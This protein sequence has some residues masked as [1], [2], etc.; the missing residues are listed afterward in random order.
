MSLSPD[1]AARR[2]TVSLFAVSFGTNVPTPIL[3]VYQQRLH[4]GATTLTAVFG[5]YAVGLVPAILLS[6][7]ASDRLGRRRVT[8]PFVALALVST[9][10]F[11]GA[12]SQEWLLFLARFLQGVV[13]GA[14]FS[15]ATAWL[16]ELAG[17][18]GHHR[19]GRWASVAMTSGFSTGVL[20]SGLLA[21]WAPA[22]TVLPYLVHLAIMVVGVLALKGIP[23]T[24][25]ARAAGPQP[26][27]RLRHGAAL[28]FWLL[29]APTAVCVYAFPSVALTVVP[30]FLPPQ[31]HPIAF[32]G[33]LGAVT[34]GSGTLAALRGRGLGEAAGPS[35]IACGAS[36]YA[37]SSLAVATGSLPLA[38]GAAVLLGIGNGLTLSAGL[39][40]T[41]HLAD[42]QARGML[43]SVFY[44]LAYVGFAAP[45]LSAL[46]IRLSS[47]ATVLAGLAATFG[48]LA[49]L[50][51]LAWRPLTAR[52]AR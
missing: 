25:R 50:V 31:G 7:P 12:A 6:G 17:A 36:G 1:R 51:A 15:V 23:E 14:V 39:A 3:L 20:T 8:V 5:A 48:V 44:A 52:V 29:A 35:G 37:A 30:L 26:K 42:P 43:T 16:A 11:L 34:L 47:P 32:T 38:L 13:A 24:R 10:L 33:L 40:L 19:A 21:Q 49:V 41:Q 9:G 28:A 18:E 45:F 4:L 2:L 27:P 46:L 22:P